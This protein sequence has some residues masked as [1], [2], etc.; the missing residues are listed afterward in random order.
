[1]SLLR[2]LLAWLIMAA[3]PLQG[4]AAAS[5]VF[6]KGAHHAQAISQA[7]A[8][9]LAT[10]AGMHDHSSHSHATQAQ[11]TRAADQPVGAEIPDASH[12]CGVCASCCHSIAIAELPHWPAFAP[13]PQAE[14]AEPFLL[15]HTTPSAVLDRPPRA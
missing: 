1:M 6:C 3:I 9:S 12:K 14:L 7:E 4:F 10:A 15:I 5:M 2:L 8:P 13:I 11:A